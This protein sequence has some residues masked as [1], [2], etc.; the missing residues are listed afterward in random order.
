M[1]EYVNGINP[2][3][4]KWARESCNYTVQD[5]AASFKKDVSIIDEW[6]S[7]ER[8]PTYV[9]LE[10]LANK[11]KRPIAIF[12]FPEPPKETN[13]AEKLALRSSDIERLTPHIHILFRQASA[14]QL[15][16]MELN[17]G[18]IHQK[19]KF[20]AIFRLKQAYSPLKLANKLKCIW[21]SILTS[22][23]IGKI[24]QKHSKFGG[25][26]LRKKEFSF[27]KTPL[28]TIRLMDSVFYMMNF[29]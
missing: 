4:L 23:Q 6:E 11:Y 26:V 10:K 20:F 3:I 21:T 27:L 29:R 1:A 5:T 16:L 28:K 25:N 15:S 17:L 18:T 8:A 24:L 22:K 7:G 2:S 13:I 14:R 19:I 9:Q 12:F